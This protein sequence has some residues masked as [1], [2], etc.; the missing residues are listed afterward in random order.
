MLMY[1]STKISPR[2]D[3]TVALIMY[4]VMPNNLIFLG[5]LSFVALIDY[6]PQTLMY[7][8]GFYL[9]MSKCMSF[10]FNEIMS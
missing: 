7:S 9:M 8:I 10:P 2:V 1:T 4:T 6:I 3:A 5:M